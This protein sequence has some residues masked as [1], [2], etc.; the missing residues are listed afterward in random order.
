MWSPEL[1]IGNDVQTQNLIFFGKN[2]DSITSLWFH[3]AK[4]KLQYASIFTAKIACSL[5]FQT[6]PFDSHTCLMNFNN[7]IGAKHRITFGQ[8]NSV[9]KDEFMRLGV[10]SL[11]SWHLG[12][13]P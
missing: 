12:A 4:S 2:A 3:Y 13:S 8:P 6:F 11:A 7:W 1:Y 10:Q 5:D 9:H